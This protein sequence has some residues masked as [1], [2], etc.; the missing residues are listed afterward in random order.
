M[1]K[2]KKSPEKEKQIKIMPVNVKV[3]I[4]CRT[5]FVVDGYTLDENNCKHCGSLLFHIDRY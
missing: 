1:Q 5:C 2:Q 4:R 3:N